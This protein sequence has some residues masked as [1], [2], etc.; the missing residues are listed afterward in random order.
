MNRPDVVIVGAGMQ[1]ATMALATA[2]MGL[3]PLVVERNAIASGATGNSYGF[4]HGGLRYLQTMDV[5]RW[6]RSRHAQRW[7][8]DNYAD[9]VLPLACIMPLYRHRMRSPAAFRIIAALET[10]L[11]RTASH[12]RPLPQPGLMAP[13]DLPADYPIPRRHL[14]GAA[15]WHDLVVPD[16]KALVLAIL[17]DAG[18]TG[19][20]LMERTE[21]RDLVVANNRVVGLRVIRA[22]G[23]LEKIVTSNV[24]ICAGSWSS[25]WQRGRQSRTAA[26]LAFNL[27]L[28]IRL[29]GEAALAVSEAPG[30]GRSYFLRP[31]EG[32][33]LAGTFYRP[34][35]GAQEPEVTPDD[36][37]AF[38]RILARALPHSEIARAPARAVMA[39]LLP[40]RDGTGR[41]LSSDDTISM[42]GPAGLCH[43]LGTKLT[44][45]P[46]LSFEAAARLWPAEGRKAA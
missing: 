27:L 43:V 11:G 30:R 42:P 19:P 6:R 18:V 36:I 25:R 32:G 15:I 44:T 9:H 37:E 21:A 46:L 38:R 33:T 28:D 8:L 16:M 35:P 4:I 12:A 13:D 40:D 5:R 7:F 17:S 24:V 3:K 29:P 1:G 26:T 23:T 22:D 45:A 14:A 39:G 31:C 41:N 34:A 2:R 20:A 10:W